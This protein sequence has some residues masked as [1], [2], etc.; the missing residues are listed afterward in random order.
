STSSRASTT[1]T[2]TAC[3]RRSS[4]RYC[5]RLEWVSAKIRDRLSPISEALTTMPSM[6][7]SA[8]RPY[9]TAVE[10]LS[11]FRNAFSM[12]A[13][14]CHAAWR[15]GLTGRLTRARSA[16]QPRARVNRRLIAGPAGRTRQHH[17]I[18]GEHEHEA[19]ERR[20]RPDIAFEQ[21]GDA[22]RD[23][24]KHDGRI[25][26]PRRTDAAEQRQIGEKGEH[27]RREAEKDEGAE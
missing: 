14:I 13:S 21:G 1:S 15:G 5:I 11:S 7:K 27:R 26:R 17:E 9:S 10:P 25:A 16:R 24:G 23:D 19:G 20:Q 4:G 22:E 3:R 2:S 18:A 6:T 12:T 8:M